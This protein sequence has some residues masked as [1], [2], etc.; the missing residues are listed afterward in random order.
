MGEMDV[1][2]ENDMGRQ[3]KEW[4]KNCVQ[5]AGGANKGRVSQESNTLSQARVPSLLLTLSWPDS[6]PEG[7]SSTLTNDFQVLGREGGQN[8]S[9]KE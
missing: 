3:E 6:T 5:D 2:L 8:I 4:M 1:I 7:Q 9:S